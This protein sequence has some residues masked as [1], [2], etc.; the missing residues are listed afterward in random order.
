MRPTRARALQPAHAC[1]R[2]DRARFR[3]RSQ[4]RSTARCPELQ[5]HIERG[6]RTERLPREPR[7]AREE[8]RAEARLR[9][10]ARAMSAT[11]ADAAFKRG[12]LPLRLRSLVSCSSHQ[13]TLNSRVGDA[14]PGARGRRRADRPRPAS[15]SHARMRETARDRLGEAGAAR[16][17]APPEARRRR[18]ASAGSR[19]AAPASARGA[20]ASA[21]AR[22][23]R[24]SVSRYSRALPR[25]GRRA[26]PV[27]Q[28]GVLE[29]TELGVD[30]PVARRPEEARRSVDGCLDVVA[31]P[32]AEGQHP[33]N[34]VPGAAERL[35][36]ATG[37]IFT[38]Y[39]SER[40]AV[41]AARRLGRRS[42]C[43][44]SGGA[45][46]RSPSPERSRAAASCSL[47]RSS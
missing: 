47:M 18:R 30:L 29:S 12:L 28:T 6:H 1:A 27:D 36:T 8:D 19:R 16:A 20:P 46:S 26:L 10:S 44:P 9:S 24:L 31:R 25:A 45:T 7:R 37:Y 41:R 23:D 43:R 42:R 35:H 11:I 17:P 40:L 22:L 5:A 2:T 15:R 34:H 21:G 4:G 3:P 33:E 39:K 14:V 38:I 32:H 13:A